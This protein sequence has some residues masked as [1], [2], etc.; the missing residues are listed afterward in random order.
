MT[1][2]PACGTNAL[3][4]SVAGTP[5]CSFR[6]QWHPRRPLEGRAITFLRATGIV[7]IFTYNHS[8]IRVMTERQSS[9]YAARRMSQ[10][11]IAGFSI[12]LWKLMPI[13]ARHRCSSITR[14]TAGAHSL[15]LI[16]AALFPQA[17][18]QLMDRLVAGTVNSNFGR[19]AALVIGFSRQLFWTRQT[20]CG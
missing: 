18:R 17:Q 15:P 2:T 14:M 9:T 3:S 8:L 1:W 10:R 12:L 7:E 13:S 6:K 5:A 16:G 4:I 11:G 19:W 20:A